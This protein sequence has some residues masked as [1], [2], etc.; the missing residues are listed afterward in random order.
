MNP[1]LVIVGAFTLMTVVFIIVMYLVWL[2]RKVSGHMQG[3]IGPMEIGYHG[4]LQLIADAIKI[5]TKQDAVPEHTDKLIFRL[6]PVF[7]VLPS[8]TALAFIPFSKNL[9]FADLNVGVLLFFA[10]TSLTSMVILMAGWG[11]NNKFSLLGALRAAAQDLSY[12]VALLF[13]SVGVIILAGTLS[14]QQIVI[15]QAGMWYVF[16]QP[17]AFLLFSIAMV[18]E[19]NRTPFDLPEA[20]SEIVA[21]Y[22]T[23]YSGMRFILFFLGEYVSM[24]VLSALCVVLFLGGWLGPVLPG[25]VWFLLKMQLVIFVLMWLRWS[26][27]R[28]RVDQLMDFGWKVL[29]PLALFNIVLTG[30]GVAFFG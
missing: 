14:L 7:I 2:E 12:E 4:A 11:S 13:A 30:A 26:L 19:L 18:A 24:F 25:I 10:L 6:A 23:E 16:K 5:M 27:P 15:K 28:F 29:V 20:E 1:L 9:Q 8:L 3:R 17:L 21:G 22:F